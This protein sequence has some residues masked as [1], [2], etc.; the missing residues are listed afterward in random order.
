MSPR[1]ACRLATLGFNRVHDY[2]AGKVDWLAHGFP[3]EGSLANE[4]TAGSLAR[5]DAA[6][7]LLEASAGDARRTIA[8]S[9]YGFALVLSHDGVLLGGVRRSTL[10]GVADDSP[11]EA[12]LE[13]GPSTI[14]PHLT[15][16]ELHQRLDGSDV[17]TLVVTRP[18]GTLVGVIRRGEVPG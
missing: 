12:T 10:E 1:A 17:R 8:D 2:A 16:E 13:P 18:D 14:R 3:V 7:C 6:T 4:P 15:V 11:L 9:P 5:E